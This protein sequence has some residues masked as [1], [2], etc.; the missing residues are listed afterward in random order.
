MATR[1]PRSDA[2][3]IGAAEL[4]KLAAMHCT[5]QEVGSWFGCTQQAVSKRLARDAPLAE[6]W[7]RGW[8]KGSIS[9]RRAQFEAAQAG[10]R[11]MMIWLGKQWLGQADKIETRHLTLDAIEEELQRILAESRGR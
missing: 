11:T 9:L 4:E 3:P 2:A 7:Q 6:A 8:D 5:Q 1:K 10:D